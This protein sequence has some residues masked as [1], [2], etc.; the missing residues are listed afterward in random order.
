MSHR[1]AEAV[2]G[3]HIYQFLSIAHTFFPLYL[4]TRF[5]QPAAATMP[6]PPHT[7]PSQTSK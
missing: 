6:R 2:C 4:C 3:N 5:M 7:N 1:V